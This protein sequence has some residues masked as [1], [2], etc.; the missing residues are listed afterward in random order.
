[1]F[2]GLC[3]LLFSTSAHA[4][5]FE[6]STTG[7]VWTLPGA[8]V[9]RTIASHM[10]VTRDIR[11]YGVKCDGVTDDSAA[12]NAIQTSS[13]I[14]SAT[15]VQPRNTT[16][17]INSP[18]VWNVRKFGFDARGGTWDAQS[19]LSGTILTQIGNSGIAGDDGNPKQ[20]SFFG[21]LRIIG[22]SKSVAN[23]TTCLLQATAL[24]TTNGI[25]L[26]G[27]TDGITFASN[28]YIIDNY[29]MSI[30]NYAGIGVHFP[31]GLTNSGEHINFYGGLAA[32]GNVGFQ[33]DG[34]GVL[35]FTGF[36]FDYNSSRMGIVNSGEVFLV[37]S[38]LETSGTQLT[39]APIE[40]NGGSLHV[41]GGEAVLTGSQPFANGI[42]SFVS[43]TGG[44]A[45]FTNM[46]GNWGIATSSPTTWT[47][48]KGAVQFSYSGFGHN[49][50]RTLA[51]VSTDGSGHDDMTAPFMVSQTVDGDA[52]ARF[53]NYSA[54][55]NARSVLSVQNN[56][57]SL[58]MYVPGSNYGG[59]DIFRANIGLVRSSA[60]L[61]AL[62]LASG[63]SGSPIIFN[64]ADAEKMRL[65]S[66]GLGIGTQ[67]PTVPL[68]V[69]GTVKV[70]GL[71]SATSIAL[72]IA[73]AG[74][75][76]TV[77]VANGS[78]WLKSDG[79]ICSVISSTW[80]KYDG[81]ACGPF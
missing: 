14:P 47:K 4:A 37:N 52:P 55:T 66:T 11:D 29:N 57:G 26:Y 3:G 63:K 68:E 78:V 16:C 49:V 74:V 30:R 8:T 70:L 28:T 58:Q 43:G 79:T 50:Q 81:T 18:I 12:I 24:M 41:F 25:E 67:T 6:Q 38:W 33:N 59:T 5:A 31:S 60:A 36:S 2:C 44:Y 72:P 61:D 9:S 17:K 32:N 7:T 54:G 76:P 39:S 53:T 34:G 23:S 77:G 10:S 27:C 56:L 75:T 80:K 71:V 22:P 73:A 13:S 45:T 20:A 40:I 48:S 65:T 15:L 64:P 69:S 42:S 21:N 46:A 62:A 19:I 1:M 35:L 51:V